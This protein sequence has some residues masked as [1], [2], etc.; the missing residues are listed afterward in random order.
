MSNK[1]EEAKSKYLVT[2]NQGRVAEVSKEVYDYIRELES[3]SYRKSIELEQK[4]AEVIA[5]ID[6]GPRIHY[7]CD[8]KG[9]NGKE[10]CNNPDCHY[11]TDVT[12]AVNFNKV[13]DDIYEEKYD[14]H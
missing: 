8:R 14:E 13:L 12:H 5:S 7:V 2:L 6:K 3:V 4:L 1:S 9:C 11:T 10:G